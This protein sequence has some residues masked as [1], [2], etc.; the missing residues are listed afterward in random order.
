MAM[1]ATTWGPSV[2]LGHGQVDLPW[3]KGAVSFRKGAYGVFAGTFY[4]SLFAFSGIGVV[5]QGILQPPELLVGIAAEGD[6]RPPGEKHLALVDELLPDGSEDKVVLR[7]A[8][9]QL[10]GVGVAAD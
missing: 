7:L 5:G 8:A 6:G 9:Q 1:S 10:D 3:S 2:H 4:V